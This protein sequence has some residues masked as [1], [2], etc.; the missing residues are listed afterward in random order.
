MSISI[1]KVTT[2]PKENMKSQINQNKLNKHSFLNTKAS[3]RSVKEPKKNI[4]SFKRKATPR[5]IISSDVSEN[6]KMFKH[7]FD[8]KVN[9]T[10]KK[11]N[12]TMGHN[13]DI[14]TI[15]KTTKKPFANNSNLNKTTTDFVHKPVDSMELVLPK[16]QSKLTNRK[17]SARTNNKKVKNIIIKYKTCIR[18][19]VNISFDV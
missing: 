10:L 8:S 14:Q 12:Q 18:H 6:L 15:A 7:Y 4:R 13:E 5:H 19:L 2:H 16:K 17:E 3:S 1:D 11:L 9:K